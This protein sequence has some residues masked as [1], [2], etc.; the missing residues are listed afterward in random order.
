MKIKSKLILLFVALAIVPLIIIGTL[1]YFNAKQAMME[2]QLESLEA[3]VHLR[4]LDI[5]RMTQLRF[6]QTRQMAGSYLIRQL[7]PHGNNNPE[8]IQDMQL[9][10]ESVYFT[11]KEADAGNSFEN[12]FQVQTSIDIIGV[13]DVNGTIVANTESSLIGK[14]MPEHFIERLKGNEA[15]F[16]G[17]LFDPLT[18]RD[19]LMFFTPVRNLVT[20]Q[21]AGAITVKIDPDYLRQIYL[22]PLGLGETG[23][24]LISQIDERDNNKLKFVTAL[25]HASLDSLPGLVIEDDKKLLPAQKAVMADE[26]SGIQNDYRGID[27]LAVWKYIPGWEW[28]IVGKIDSAEIMAPIYQLRNRTLLIGFGLLIL[29][30]FLAVYLSHF[31]SD[32]LQKLVTIFT[33]LS[34]GELG[35][36]VESGRKDEIG[37]LANSADASIR[38]LQ[39]Y[40]EY[41]NTISH[42]DYSLSIEPFSDKDE[43]GVALQEMADSLRR[44]R[45]QIQSLLYDSIE[46][47][48]QLTIQHE[49]LKE[50]HGKL[51]EKQARLQAIL[52][53][54]V[55]AII[56]IDEKGSILSFNKAA[57]TIFGYRRGEVIGKNVKILM[58][59]PHQEKHVDYIRNYLETG[60]KKMIGE[61]R[62]E[63]GL[64]KDNTVFPIEIS[65][66]EVKTKDGRIFSGLITDNTYRK[67]LERHVLEIGDEERRRIGRELHDGLGQM[68]TGIRMVSENVARKLKANGVPGSDEVEDITNMAREA[69]E[70][71]RVLTSGMV[72]L[73]LENEGLCDAIKNYCNRIEKLYGINCQFLVNG[74]VEF[75]KHSDAL[76]L[77]RIV[78]ESINNAIKHG[79]AGTITIRLANSGTFTSLTIDD[80]GSGFDPDEIHN[81]GLGI[82]I[83]KYRAGILGGMLEIIRT[84][85]HLTRVR[86]IIPNEYGR[87]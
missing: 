33:G 65:I 12:N 61:Q 31:I 57:E 48:Q 72:Q 14:R 83:M 81:G 19:Y 47:T 82:Q 76:N 17:Y 16:S 32:P 1:S 46:H 60:E 84:E 15:P 41:A 34:K 56:T 5:E 7:D 30:V 2:Q 26:G 43:L 10:V 86:C 78:Q 55:S 64:K 27:V 36:P 28:G 75:E 22:S 25:R 77:F 71:A 37:Q 67:E 51:E 13:W 79:R 59:L 23:E 44:Q 87:F 68:L 49:N 58:P 3:M 85:E 4:I 63:L 70:Y 50:F 80:D 8:V 40:V 74:T 6:E 45:N 66:R 21:F 9:L 11:L 62:N 39:N 18:G 73:E 24:I 29:S 54:C 35:K 20:D 42:G 52:D 53:T 38:Y 69:D